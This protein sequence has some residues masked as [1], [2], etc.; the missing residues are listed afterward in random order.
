MTAADISLDYP[1]RGRARFAQ[2]VLGAVGLVGAIDLALVPMLIEP[3][4]LELD[5]S[6][7]QVGLANTTVFA[8]ATGLA[9]APSGM[10]A[11]RIVRKR[12]LVCA[13][14]MWVAALLL[15]AFAQGMA[16]LVCGKLLMGTASAIALPTALSMLSDY[17]VPERRAMA[18]ST[19]AFGQL[20]GTAAAIFLG[21][22]GFSWLGRWAAR[23][24]SA[25]FGLSPW[26]MVFV[27]FALGATL[28]I[29]ALASL[30]EPSRKEVQQAGGGTLKELW[31]YRAFLLPLYAG[32]ACLVGLSTEITTWTTPALI[33][34]YDLQ[35][36]DFAGWYGTIQF[37]T[38]VIGVLMSGKLAELAR[39]RGGQSGMM[40]PAA[41]G[42]LLCAP[43]ACMALAPSVFGFATLLTIY[44]LAYA[45]AM[46]V[47]VI[48]INFRIP[49]E[50]RGLAFGLN[51]V[52]VA[53]AT[54]IS[55]PLVAQVSQWL[56]GEH[57]LGR[58]MAGV[59]VPFALAAAL[60]FWF[61]SRSSVSPADADSR[62]NSG[63]IPREDLT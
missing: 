15:I 62:P 24:P 33:R 30:R 32:L 45:P 27:L 5:L 55:A 7:V 12:L 28:L 43:A 59:G 48:A 10:L 25:L 63:L 57:M 58:A 6:D 36:G 9:S 42:A 46:M 11:D 26:R 20:L 13:V 18:T 39:R 52:C 35:P 40:L 1:S 21:G 41:I 44:C 14:L 29:P 49:N 53:V 47:P 3:I 50:L 61:A 56:G 51:V 16:L 17:F 31:S 4:R 8:I 60:C 2:V 54:A 22:Y 38:G 37:A 23:D 34:L 19:Y